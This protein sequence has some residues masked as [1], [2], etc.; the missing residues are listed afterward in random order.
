MT[1]NK[2][3]AHPKNHAA[4]MRVAAS[5]SELALLR[6]AASH[7]AR[8]GRE[9]FG[10]YSNQGGTQEQVQRKRTQSRMGPI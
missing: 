2:Y 1:Y 3:P 9:R 6:A 10:A 7:S 8:K 5:H 4:L